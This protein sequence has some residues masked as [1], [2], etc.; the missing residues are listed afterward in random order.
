MPFGKGTKPLFR[1]VSLKELL[2]AARLRVP[3]GHA[4]PDGGVLTI[5]TENID[6]AGEEPDDGHSAPHVKIP[7][8]DAG[9]GM[10]PEVLDPRVQ[11]LL[12]G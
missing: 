4:T 5:T 2:S 9:T 1:V 10:T 12:Q 11:T 3:T 8:N 6:I 7:V